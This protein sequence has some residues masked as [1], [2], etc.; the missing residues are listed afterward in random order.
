MVLIQVLN[1]IKQKNASRLGGPLHKLT[2]LV[3]L[4]ADQKYYK[5]QDWSVIL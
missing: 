3:A 5:H 1:Q 4:Q 2:G